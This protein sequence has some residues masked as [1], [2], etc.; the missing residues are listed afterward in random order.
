[1]N[2]KER[3][4]RLNL[5]SI[6]VCWSIFCLAIGY[7]WAMV[8]YGGNKAAEDNEYPRIEVID[9]SE[10]SADKNPKVGMKPKGW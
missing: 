8:V 4:K 5:L 3:N 6:L 2:E 7:A 10:V 9:L 1:M